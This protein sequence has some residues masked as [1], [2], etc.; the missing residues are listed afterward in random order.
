MRSPKKHWIIIALNDSYCHFP[1]CTF[2]G[3]EKGAQKRADY[4][5]ANNLDICGTHIVRHT[6]ESEEYIRSTNKTGKWYNLSP[7]LRVSFEVVRNSGKVI[8]ITDDEKEALKE[9]KKHRCIYKPIP[10]K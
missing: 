10:R 9:A 2:Y 7:K 3:T 6:N 4:V 1:I 5:K 8:L